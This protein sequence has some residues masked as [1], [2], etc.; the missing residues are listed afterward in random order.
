M[1]KVDVFGMLEEMTSKELAYW[2]A[3]ERVNGPIGNARISYEGAMDRTVLA[4]CHGNKIK[5]PSKMML[6]RSPDMSEKVVQSG[7]QIMAGLRRIA[8]L[9]GGVPDG[10]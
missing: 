1:N 9:R 4:N 3:W 7:E 10:E 5:H 6:Y 2:M 8:Q